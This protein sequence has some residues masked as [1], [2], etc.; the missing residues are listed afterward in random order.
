[1]LYIH[2]IISSGL[3][4]Y[5]T[6]LCRLRTL[7]IDPSSTWTGIWTK[8][9]DVLKLYVDFY[10]TKSSWLCWMSLLSLILL[11][12]FPWST[13]V[14]CSDVAPPGRGRFQLARFSILW[15]GR[16]PL[17]IVDNDNTTPT[18]FPLGTHIQ[19]SLT[20]AMLYNISKFGHIWMHLI[21]PQ[22]NRMGLNRTGLRVG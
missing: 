1:M 18:L 5:A 19:T 6:P 21:L 16:L 11:L 20:F 14:S 15:H 22:M 12:L 10:N 9:F 2:T 3:V 4:Q 17:F 8:Y 7:S 13:T